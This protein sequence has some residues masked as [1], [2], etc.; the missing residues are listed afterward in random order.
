MT[1]PQPRTPK[2]LRHH[3]H[4]ASCLDCQAEMQAEREAAAKRLDRAT[5]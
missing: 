5:R 4:L 2:C 3:V 1:V